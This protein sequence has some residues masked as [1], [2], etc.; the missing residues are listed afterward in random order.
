MGGTIEKSDPIIEIR[1]RCRQHK[2]KHLIHAVLMFGRLNL[3]GIA[4][5][6][7]ISISVLNRVYIGEAYL[8][9]EQAIKLAHLFLLCFDD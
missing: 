6:L 8:E 5:L 1:F 2:Q 7:D 3:H 4:N 9:P